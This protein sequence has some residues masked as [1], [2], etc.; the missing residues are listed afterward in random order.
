VSTVRTNL[1]HWLPLVFKLAIGAL[2]AWGLHRTILSA[3]DDLREQGWRAS[4]LRPAWLA[5]AGGLY[6]LAFVPSAFFWRHVLA[7]LGQP[8]HVVPALRAYYIGHLGKYVPGKAMVIVLRAA[9]LR[10]EGVGTAVATA[11]VFYETLSTMAVGALLAATILAV[12]HR[13]QVQLVLVALALA[14]VAGAPAAPGIFQWLARL[15]GIE[16]VAPGVIDR[17]GGLS[18]RSL[19]VW[20][21]AVA[22]GWCLLGAS[23]WATLQ[24]IE[25]TPTLGP[26]REI[27]LCTAV[28]ALSIVA[29]FASMIP[30]GIGVRE[31]VIL[32]LLAPAVGS[33]PALV[34]AV[35]SRL[36]GLVSELMISIILYPVGRGRELGTAE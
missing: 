35:L 8:P 7:T 34:C 33:G 17:L 36:T 22:A 29:G 32:E 21:L 26:A 4:S 23:L 6:L 10:S 24:S 19:L 28:A 1:K 12:W 14:I 16:R 15:A 9:C 20:W 3:L 25:Y 27:V 11:S 13:D 2:L 31:L 18:Y 30:G 5:A